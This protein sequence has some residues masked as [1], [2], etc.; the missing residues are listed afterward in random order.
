MARG[1]RCRAYGILRA[2]RGNFSIPACSVVEKYSILPSAR[3]LVRS[4]VSSFV[5]ALARR[6]HVGRSRHSSEYSHPS[7]VTGSNA[8]RSNPFSDATARISSSVASDAIF[9]RVNNQKPLSFWPLPVR[10]F[11]SSPVGIVG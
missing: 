6:F 1:A 2:R 9:S 3:S 11:P 7:C 5:R 8:L 4:F 10:H